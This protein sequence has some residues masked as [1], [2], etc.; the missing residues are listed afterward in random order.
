M[1]GQKYIKSY[2]KV[3]S[4]YSAVFGMLRRCVKSMNLA[5]LTLTVKYHR[6]NRLESFQPTENQ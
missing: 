3:L 4:F 2:R 5:G 1:H 6:Q